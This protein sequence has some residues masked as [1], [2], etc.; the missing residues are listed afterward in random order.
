MASEVLGCPDDDRR[1]RPPT[2]TATM[3]ARP[4]PRRMPASKR[5][6]TMSTRRSS[7]TGSSTTSGQ[8]DRKRPSRGA[9]TISEADC[10]MLMRTR[11]AGLPSAR[12]AVVS[13][14]AASGPEHRR[15]AERLLTCRRAKFPGHARWRK[16]RLLLR[17]RIVWLS[18]EKVTPGCAAAR[19]S[20]A[21]DD[22]RKALRGWKVRLRIVWPT[23][24]S[25]KKMKHGPVTRRPRAENH[26][27]PEGL[28]HHGAGRGIG[29]DIARAALAAGHAVVA[30]GRISLACPRPWVHAGT[31]DGQARRHSA[32][33]A[34]AAVRAAVDRFR[35]RR[36]AGQQI[37]QLPRRLLRG[38]DAG[39]FEQHRGEP[40]R[41]HEHCP[42][43]PAGHAQA[44]LGP[45]RLDLLDRRSGRLRVQHP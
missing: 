9:M 21:L 3:C 2:W 40:R 30:A 7:V 28:V 42:R 11:P 1:W 35:R 23:T 37:G 38:A 20:S 44:A 22:G 25:V 17:A 36:R 15:G 32:W 34:Q 43:C 33:C 39:Q 16:T 6:A 14:T 45:H 19:G 10:D 12:L 27:K 5:S 18:A 4:V 13:A 26:G 41:S 31:S 29:V 8:A 24:E